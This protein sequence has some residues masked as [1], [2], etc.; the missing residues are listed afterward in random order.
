MNGIGVKHIVHDHVC[1]VKE[2]L[3][4]L[5]LVR[6]WLV[7][8]SKSFYYDAEN[9]DKKRQKDT[10]FS[11]RTRNLIPGEV[12]FGLTLLRELGRLYGEERAEVKIQYLVT[13]YQSF[14][15]RS[16]EEPV[17]NVRRRLGRRADT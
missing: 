8:F 6:S 14:C 12:I 11:M 7:S 9:R 17:K 5:V 1:W 4:F 15:Q 13:T 3:L 16:H 2:A 10:K